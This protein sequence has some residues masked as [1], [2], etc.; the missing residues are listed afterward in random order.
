MRPV[1]LTISAF[2][3]Y[4][5]KTEID[6][7]RLGGQG[8]Y[9]ITGDTG[10]GKTTIFDAI[11]FALY[12][13]AS[14]EVR[15]AEM[16][17]SKYAAIDVPTYV[18]FAFEYRGRRYVVRR[19]PEYLRPKGRGSGYTTQRADAWLS[20]PDDREP[21]TK[22][23]EVTRAVT[24]LIGLDGRQFAQIAMIAQGDFRKLLFAGTEERSGIF[25]QIFGTGIYQRLQEELR[26]AAREQENKYKERRRSLF[27]DMD[28]IVCS[29]DGACAVKMAEMKR[30]SFDGRFG[31]GIA[32]LEELCREEAAAI[33][34]L[35]ETMEVLDGHIQGEDRLIGT[36]RKVKEQQGELAG[37]EEQLK[38]QEPVLLAAEEAR[39][40]AAKEAE[41]C[42]GLALQIR[43]E[44]GRLQLF[45]RLEAAQEQQR[46]KEREAV[47]AAGRRAERAAEKEERDAQLKGKQERA[48]ALASVGEERARLEREKRE[49]GHLIEELGQRRGDWEEERARERDTK[50]RIDDIGKETGNLAEEIR[51]HRE[52]IEALADRDAALS[53][54]Q[55]WQ[56]KIAEQTKVL[57]Q[58]AGEQEKAAGEVEQVK[59]KLTF[60]LSCETALQTAKAEREKEM[61][62]LRDAAGT[63]QLCRRNTQEAGERLQTFRER[64]ERL[65]DARAEFEKRKAACQAAQ[66][67]VNTCR[68]RL[69]GYAAEQEKQKDADE[70]LFSLRQKAA[71]LL[72][73]GET[74]EKLLADIARLEDDRQELRAAQ[75]TYRK[76]AAEK[77]ALFLLW[78][79]TERQFLDAQAGL[80]A[81]ELREGEA[82][83]V[84]GST[85]H[86]APA[87]V[88]GAVPDKEELDRTKERLSEAERKAERSSAR[89]GQIG[90]SLTERMQAAEEMAEKL[91][92]SL[93]QCVEDG[94]LPEAGGEKGDALSEA[95]E[96]KGGALPEIGGEKGDAFPEPGEERDDVPSCVAGETLLRGTVEPGRALSL[97]KEK[98]TEAGVRIG[99]EQKTLARAIR[100]AE[101]QV[102]KKTETEEALKACSAELE[103]LD[104]LYRER[105]QALASVRGRLAEQ[106]RQ[107]E[108]SV[109][110]LELPEGC[111]REAAEI[112]AYLEAEL[113]QCVE[114]QRRAEADRERLETLKKEEAEA[115]GEQE[116]LRGQ[117]AEKR[118]RASQLEGQEEV[119]QKRIAE[120]LARAG[121]LLRETAD[122]EVPEGLSGVL[123]ALQKSRRRLEERAARLQSELAERE[124]AAELLRQKTERHDACREKADGLLRQLEGTAARRQEKTAQLSD[125]LCRWQPQLRETL[126][127][128]TLSPDELREFAGLAESEWRAQAARLEAALQEN[129][130]KERERQELEGQIPVLQE[131]IRALAAELERAGAQ[132]AG[133]KAECDVWK[134]KIAE[135]AA[136]TG[137]GQR[138][139]TEENIRV[140]AERKTKL[141]AA[142]EEAER[143]YTKQRHEKERLTSA[144]E[145]LQKQ[146]AAS[147]EAGSTP[148]EEAAARKAQWQEERK[149][150]AGRRDEAYSAYAANCKIYDKVKMGQSEITAAE[151]RYAWMK[152]L[153][154]TAGGTLGGK[155]K[156][157][158]ETYVQ[159]TYFD[160]VIRRANLR[161]LTMSGGQYELKRE[162]GGE[163]RREKA[164]L[165]L[166]VIDH[167][168]GTE[169]SVKT[170][171]GGETFQASLSLA[172]GLSDEIQSYAGGIRMD[173]MFV[174]EGF[175]SL[176]EEALGQ[177][178]KSLA[179]LTEGNRLVGIIS[180][181]S[182]LK[183]RIEKKII[184]TKC[185]DRDGIGSTVRIE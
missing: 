174:D 112:T 85:H 168:N 154:D 179:G 12:G 84:C 70:L 35:D 72:A 44:Q 147:G 1:K 47:E 101:R 138:S 28:G 166:S 50:I 63:E 144:V 133:K 182:A 108:D 185:R 184:V 127:A 170:L 104:G 106:E 48:L 159:M 87:E 21:V 31:E 151:T 11:T 46:A 109:S 81:R 49:I 68:G 74:Q 92:L 169:R 113:E 36:I 123:C 2:G 55:E 22:T 4:A 120:E 117:I 175:G 80:L 23:K 79:Q 157:E 58:E 99:S 53:Q 75:E 52:R 13:E 158:L 119:R 65:A 40:K 136:Q 41:A 78:Q 69:D 76:A 183:E 118:E 66:E 141:E 165:E 38:K 60:L 135:L 146:I 126:T 128:A 62:A 17:R 181:V 59:E 161:L 56:K 34:R 171:S 132:E 97:L 173:S 45:D 107:W 98:I 33:K 61:D 6:F 18:E 57:E 162:T 139:E 37:R 125:T 32:L 176:D 167:Y 160:R 143:E 134:E 180:H 130:E 102:Q 145:L 27:Q 103:Q 149:A 24:E 20:Y 90:E 96:E 178:L 25:R 42:E 121:S 26:A 19:N 100:E 124:Q 88:S 163:N 16:F 15:R 71:A 91:H 115:Q 155:Q 142:L 29:G 156:I 67:Q 137:P 77:D 89:A 110:K 83:P 164:G 148:E 114:R 86:P 105:E 14:G 140:L 51:V 9:L 7:E 30:D 39:D 5:G 116:R 153:A 93:L 8:I 129:L 43:E 54:T 82:C 152:A 73:H 3:P 10:A 131:N 150:C 64:S 95:G 111:G 177:A 172:L 122:G 94:A